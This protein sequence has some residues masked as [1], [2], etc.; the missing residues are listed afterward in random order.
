MG[1]GSRNILLQVQGGNFRFLVQDGDRFVLIPQDSF[2]R[3]LTPK[4]AANVGAYN[5]D[6]PDAFAFDEMVACL[7]AL[8]MGQPVSIPMYI[9]PPPPSLLYDSY[10]C[11][12]LQCRAL[13]SLLQD[14]SGIGLCESNLLIRS[15]R[16]N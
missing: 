7:R 3:N 10:L 6:H 16:V 8:K 11:N 12:M 13:H 9:P 4:E 5:F 14:M 2:Y 15:G 1:W